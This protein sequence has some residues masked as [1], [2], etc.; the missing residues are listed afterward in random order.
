MRVFGGANAD[1]QY[2]LS[3]Q[4]QLGLCAAERQTHTQSIGKRAQKHLQHHY[5]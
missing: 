1:N 4:T 2:T 3:R 5:D